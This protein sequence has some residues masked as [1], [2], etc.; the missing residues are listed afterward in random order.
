MTGESR[1]GPSHCTSSDAEERT[2]PFRVHPGLGSWELR[3]GGTSAPSYGA[4]DAF[5][6]LPT[7]SSLPSHVVLGSGG[8]G[9][10]ASL[11][12]SPSFSSSLS[13]APG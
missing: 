7:C 10:A 6:G 11:S 9:A 5:R 1:Q 8:G 12:R 4:S 13:K 2:L 3:V